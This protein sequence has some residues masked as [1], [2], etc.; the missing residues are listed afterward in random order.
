[1]AVRP[2]AASRVGTDPRTIEGTSLSAEPH[3][4]QHRVVLLGHLYEGL[5]R[6]ERNDNP[7]RLA[8]DRVEERSK[9]VLGRLA[10]V[11][12]GAC[13]IGCP[14]GIRVHDVELS[15]KPSG[16]VIGEAQ[17]AGP[18]SSA[19]TPQTTARM[20]SASSG[21]IA[22]EGTATTGHG[23]SRM[24]V[25]ATLPSSPALAVDRPPAATTISSA[26]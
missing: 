9:T 22:S 6:W 7:M 14:L 5:G 17:V 19:A 12:V 18:V 10:Q 21:A 4:D 16:E 11:N 3:Y 26:S 2:A 24:S 20:P 1:M 13:R 8:A 15:T 23:A 25:V